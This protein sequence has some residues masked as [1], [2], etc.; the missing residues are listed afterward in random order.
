MLNNK[1][2][3]EFK[4]AKKLRINILRNAVKVVEPHI[5]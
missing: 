4:A 2:I 5:E 3:K 1:E